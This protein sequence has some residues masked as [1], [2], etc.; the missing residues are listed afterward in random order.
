[1]NGTAITGAPSS[2]SVCVSEMRKLLDLSSESCRRI[3]RSRRSA[4]RIL[5]WQQFVETCC[6]HPGR[7]LKTHGQVQALLA[8]SCI[9]AKTNQVEKGIIAVIR[10]RYILF[11]GKAGPCTASSIMRMSQEL[12]K[13]DLSESLPS[14]LTSLTGQN[15]CVSGRVVEPFRIQVLRLALVPGSPPRRHVHQQR[16]PLASWST[17]R[18]GG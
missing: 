5:E 3:L 7:N 17:Q 1:M 10:T 4:L 13:Q 2:A 14:N 9:N 16:A 15:V 6:R 11:N 8:V 12:K 18:G